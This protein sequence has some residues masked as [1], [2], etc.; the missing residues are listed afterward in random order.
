MKIVL[1]CRMKIS[2]LAI[3]KHLRQKL[4][5]VIC[6]I[7]KF[8]FLYVLR[9]IVIRHIYLGMKLKVLILKKHNINDDAVYF[10]FK[11]NS[12]K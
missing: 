1:A 11:I 2:A 5:S 9:T 3:L 12:F 10:L 8:S 4:T 7:W 6:S